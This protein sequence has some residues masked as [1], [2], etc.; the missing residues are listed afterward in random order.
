MRVKQVSVFAEN[1]PGRLVDILAV[2][3]KKKI[4]IRALSISETAEFGIVRM[5]LDKPDEAL[6]ALRESKF[7]CRTDWILGALIPDVPGGLLNTV[8]LPLAGQGINI[9]YLYA[10]IERAENN[11]AMV[12]LK[13]DDL[14]K[15]ETI[16]KSTIA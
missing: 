15:A 9:K 3:D 13:P 7:T 2:L 11:R 4:S 8:A 12:V 14:E 16:L 6:E 5:V 1:I 10:Y